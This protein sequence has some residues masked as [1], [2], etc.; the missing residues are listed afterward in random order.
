MVE[1][2]QKKV[3]VLAILSLVFGC[4]FII[5]IFGNYYSIPALI[6]G[7]IALVNISKEEN[8]LKGRGLAITGIV[9]GVLK[10]IL[11]PLIVLFSH[12]SESNLSRARQSANE[13]LAK[14]TMR[15]IS[16]AI[17]AYAK[18]NNGKYPMSES[19]LVIGDVPY[20]SKFYDHRVIGGYKYLL[21][22]KTNYYLVVALPETY[23]VTG[24][25]II[26]VG[27]GGVMQDEGCK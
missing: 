21:K 10:I 26:T 20:L 1:T 15:I 8:N 14:T 27:T 11:I 12:I 18:E 4:F 6:L 17:E 23:G 2:I 9:L 16:T 7:I 25:K 24:T 13:S 22:F 5:P 3:S 19:V